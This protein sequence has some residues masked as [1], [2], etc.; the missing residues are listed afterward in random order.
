MSDG[1]RA[2]E[3][4]DDEKFA[5]QQRE[6]L[7]ASLRAEEDDGGPDYVDQT[8]YSGD[9]ILG[10]LN[11]IEAAQMVQSETLEKLREGVNSIGG[12]M[13]DVADAFGQ[14]MEQVSKGGIGALLGGM[15]GKKN[16]GD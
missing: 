13:N 9:Q 7:D 12:M 5:Q 6:T 15:M 4:G 8:V 1:F 16:N 3:Y 10:R 14:I 2:T 11:A